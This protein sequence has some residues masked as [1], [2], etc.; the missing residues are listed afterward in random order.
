MTDRIGLAGSVEPGW[1]DLGVLPDP[2]KFVVCHYPVSLPESGSA[3]LIVPLL[4]TPS[5]VEALAAGLVGLVD[6]LREK[7]GE[8][9]TVDD[10][11]RP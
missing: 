6:R 2:A 1:C 5:Q 9:K 8:T 3:T 4:M 7:H 11:H 10:P